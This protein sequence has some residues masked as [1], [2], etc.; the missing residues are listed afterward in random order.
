MGMDLNNI[1]LI[2]LMPQF[3]QQDPIAKGLCA[4]LQPQFRQ[5]ADETKICLLM[6]RISELNGS[7][8]DELAWE[9][10]IDFWDA[11]ADEEKKRELLKNSLK[12]HMT[13]GTPAAVETLIQTMF[14]DGYV[15]EWFEYG[16][17]PYMFRVI[18]NNASVTTDKATQFIRALNSVK[19]LRSWLEKVIITL[20]EPLDFY[21]AGIVHTGDHITVRQVG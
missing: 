3:M 1:N 12:I 19:N 9:L 5:L 13:R 7:I 10:H 8:L 16:G 4:A 17:E 2:S 15:E 6:P 11:G 20:S 14:N 18:T 21:Y